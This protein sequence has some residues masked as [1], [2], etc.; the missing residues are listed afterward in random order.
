MVENGVVGFKHIKPYLFRRINTKIIA[1]CLV[2]STVILGVLLAFGYIHLRDQMENDLAE[3]ADNIAA[4]LSR[5]LVSPVWNV[6]QENVRQILLAEMKNKRVYSIAIFEEMQGSL[7]TGL[8]RNGEWEPVEYDGGSSGEF[9]ESTVEL[10]TGEYMLGTVN[11]KLTTRFMQEDLKKRFFTA[12]A[13]AAVLEGLLV[14]ALYLFLKKVLIN[15]LL[16]LTQTA[17]AIT[18]HK[19]Y[20][21]RAQKQ[22]HDEIG[23]LVDSFNSMLQEIESRDK[24]V[25]SYAK[26][27]EQKVQAR[28]RDVTTAYQK[29]L[30]S[31]RL[32][33][34]AKQ[35][36]ENAN[37]A[38]SEFLANMSHEIRTPMNAIIGM[39]DLSL[40]TELTPKL[41]EYLTV[42]RS[43]ARSLLDLINDILDFSKIEAGKLEFESIPFKPQELLEQVTD[44]FRDKVVEKEIDFVV[45]VAPEVPRSLIGDPLRLRQVLVNLIGN[46][47]KFTSKG[48]VSVRVA[49]EEVE[50]DHVWLRFAVAD[51]GIGID[52]D[53]MAGLF[54]A[55]TQADGSTTR[56][57]GGTGLGLAIS[58]K[59]VKMMGGGR[60]EVESTLGEGSTFSF[61]AR[62]GATGAEDVPQYPAPEALKDKRALV[63]DDNKASR[64][65]IM[66]M[67]E[68]FGFAVEEAATGEEAL[69]LITEEKD[70][71]PFGMALIDW[72]LPGIDGLEVARQIRNDPET[73]DMAVVIMSAFAREEEIRK[74]DEIGVQGFLFKPVKQST[75]FDT[76]METFGLGSSIVAQPQDNTGAL[77]FNGVKI[78]LAEDNKA[79]Q[80]VASEILAS[81]GVDVDI[82]E[83]GEE[84]VKAVKK[85]IYKA[86]LMD[87][88]M[89]VMDG[90]QATALIRRNDAIKHIPIIAMTAHAMVG[91]K[92]KCLEAGMDD[93]VTKPVDR[94]ELFRTLKKWLPS[95]ATG[96]AELSPGQRQD[97]TPAMPNLPGVDTGDALRRLGVSVEIYTKLLISFAKDQLLVLE[98]LKQAVTDGN[99]LE[100]ARL[101]HS[102]SGAGGSLGM[103]ELRAVG[104]IL[105]RQAGKEGAD[106]GPLLSAV[107]E[108]F[109]NAAASIATLQQTQPQQ[110]GSGTDAAVKTLDTENLLQSL[111]Q[112]A[113][114]IE[115]SDPM[116]CAEIME[117]IGPMNWPAGLNNEKN[118]LTRYIDSYRFDEAEELITDIRAK[119]EQET[120]DETT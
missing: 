28:T 60:I 66:R 104:K 87:V 95:D 56:K 79:N 14:L 75:L 98:E 117:R 55:F 73:K 27:L 119:L 33:E 41:R 57:F 114:G 100:A 89:P 13:A 109:H 81:A 43:S 35:T 47:F 68:R 99:R 92:E 116:E 111:G 20:S 106:L 83:N 90:M 65:V 103:L 78:L 67:L 48:N 84:A 30:H 11:I 113:E 108:E 64:S 42:V 40:N 36:A 76:V 18:R 82:A 70:N 61:P 39:S 71:A 94:F 101:A 97:D 17:A 54:E 21:L 5:V 110:E 96:G 4:R 74:A 23:L 93:Y 105:E 15:P 63:V 120:S 12:F 9:I 52:N 34:Q 19:D 77:N 25:E 72:K 2:A 6:D 8:Q 16:G 45:D 32:L 7:F 62:F 37:K 85:G 22:S 115:D 31:S 29:L 1:F 118:R 91:D 69:V 10:R 3:T 59:L 24:K 107:E 50:P 53:N 51:T 58:N 88:Q 44:I 49:V 102:L 38:K 86:V 112:L 80:Q 26:E 46:A